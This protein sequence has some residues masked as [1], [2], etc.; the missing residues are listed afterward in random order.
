MGL[1]ARTIVARLADG[2]LGGAVLFAGLVL[3]TVVVVRIAWVLA[4]NR[5]DR[6]LD[7]ARRRPAAP[8]LGHA[9]VVSWCGMRGLV[10]L[11]TALALPA[12]FPGRD[13]IQLSALAVVLGTLVLQGLT[14]E[15][16]IRRL[17]LGPDRSFDGDVAAAR[18]LLLEAGLASLEGRAGDVAER[19]R[20][21]YRAA[22][23]ATR[24]GRHPHEDGDAP[25]RLKAV[26]AQ[27][28]R[29]A[30]LRRH[31]E[32]EDDVFHTLEQELDWAELAAS[33]PARWEVVEG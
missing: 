14:L 5:I 27:R 11:A 17:R 6:L 29:L 21:D 30:E 22:D 3:A 33:P 18:L 23:A 8:P 12:D 10:T 32:I 16:L 19:L 26:K 25:L 9:L 28:N 7:R 4:Y 1:Q 2:A 31:G 15:P 20:A 24:H 13:L